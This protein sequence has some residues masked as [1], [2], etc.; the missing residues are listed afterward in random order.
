MVNQL[1]VIVSILAFQIVF[2]D[3]ITAGFELVCEISSSSPSG[4]ISVNCSATREVQHD[5]I[6]HTVPTIKSLNFSP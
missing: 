3:S 2:G 6:I 1:H 5:I 4:P